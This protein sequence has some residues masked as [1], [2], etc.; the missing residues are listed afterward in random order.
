MNAIDLARQAYAPVRPALKTE[1]AVEA[2]LLTRITA[3]L[4]Q[5]GSDFPKAA[6][7][8]HENRRFWTTMAADVSAAD[9]KLAP[10]LRA[11]IF[12]LAEFSE[13]HGAQFLKG[14]VGLE[15]LIDINTAVIRGLNGVGAH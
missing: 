13:Q 15:P 3:R 14:K 5:A 2:Q 6:A 1:R 11:Q 9:N 10:E 12:Y 7:A 4:T 8:V